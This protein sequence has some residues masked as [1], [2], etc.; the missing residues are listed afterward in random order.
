LEELKSSFAQLR[1]CVLKLSDAD[2]D[3]PQTMRDRQTTLRGA[4]LIVD[5]HLGEHLGQAIAYARINGLVSPWKQEL[6]QQR[7]ADKPKP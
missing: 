7:P 6:Q 3:K 1:A 5:R 4:L 2:L